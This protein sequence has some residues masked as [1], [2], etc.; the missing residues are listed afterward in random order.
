MHIGV[1]FYDANGAVARRRRYRHDPRL[2]AHP[3]IGADSTWGSPSESVAGGA[4][5]NA[6][7]RHR[8]AD[9]ELFDF[10]IGPALGVRANPVRQSLYPSLQLFRKERIHL[11]VRKSHI[12]EPLERFL[13]LLIRL[14]I[15]ARG[16]GVH[17]M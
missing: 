4:N 17:S 8:A 11:G 2:L 7:E 5:R 1:P 15:G 16:A 9:Q 10:L 6:R 14:R 13:S 3:Q 12:F